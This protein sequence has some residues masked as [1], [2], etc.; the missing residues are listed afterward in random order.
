[1]KTKDVTK[2]LKS[3]GWSAH[4]DEVGDRYT[5]W[6]LADRRV[7]I[8]YG[9]RNFSDGQQLD[10]T[11]STSS[12]AFSE[13]YKIIDDCG[14]NYASLIVKRNGW[15]VRAPEITE[16]HVRQSS[17]DAISWA[18]EQNLDAALKE[19]AAL[20]TTAPGTGPV[21]HL[22]ALAVLGDIDRLEYYQSRFV[23]GDRLGFVPYI[24]KE[25]VDRAVALAKER[26]NSKN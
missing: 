15:K 14:S 16:T 2:L 19:K 11:L 17:A 7:Q 18:K 20:P 1:M 13:A 26:N 22:A 3:L 9:V 4:T 12:E 24:T 23:A 8:I 21:L 5:I 6:Q 25:Y 10:G